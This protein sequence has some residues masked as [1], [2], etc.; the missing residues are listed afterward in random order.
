[1]AELAPLLIVAGGT[2]LGSIVIGAT[3][4]WTCHINRRAS[5][6]KLDHDR[7]LAVMADAAA[8]RERGEIRE[9]EILT[10]LIESIIAFQTLE[11]SDPDMRRLEQA[12]QGAA[13]QVDDVQLIAFAEHVDPELLPRAGYLLRTPRGERTATGHQAGRAV[14]SDGD[15]TV[16]V[17]PDQVRT[18]KPPGDAE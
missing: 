6:D 16:I 17:I 15:G 2:S 18:P 7:S 8:G 1:M 9:R 14:Y 11:W 10:R 3:S 13:L 4:V 12:I 5:K